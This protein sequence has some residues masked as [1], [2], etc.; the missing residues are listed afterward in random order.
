MKIGIISDTHDDIDNVQNAIEI[1]REERFESIIHAGDFIFPGV[2]DEFKKLKDELP[3]SSIIGVLG[4]N[5]GEKLILLKKFMELGGK[6][7]GEFGDIVIDGLRFGIY[8]GT[9]ENLREAAIKRGIY[10]V[11]IHGHTHKRREEKIGQTLV[12]NPGTAHKKVKSAS[13]LFEEE[14]GIMIFDTQTKEYKYVH[15]P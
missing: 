7:E 2:I 13:G 15:L 11:F 9:S 12:L 3:L 5:D 8:H 14:G 6:L 1:F 4:N 10:D